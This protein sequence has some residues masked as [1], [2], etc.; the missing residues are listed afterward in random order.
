M[1]KNNWVCYGDLSTA[2][3]LQLLMKLLSKKSKSGKSD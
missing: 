1:Q 2:R 3:G